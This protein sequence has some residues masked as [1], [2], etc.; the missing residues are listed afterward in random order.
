M[1][2]MTN[3]LRSLL[4]LVTLANFSVF[5]KNT[6]KSAAIKANATV[7]TS[8]NH[9]ISTLLSSIKEESEKHTTIITA[10]EDASSGESSMRGKINWLLVIVGI[11]LFA[12][13]ALVLDILAVVGEIKGKPVINWSNINS[14]LLLAFV[15]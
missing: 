5:A 10:G 9:E 11:L 8:V 15:V 14:K 6:E 4:L 2:L 7:T 12:V 13:I 3:V 1:K